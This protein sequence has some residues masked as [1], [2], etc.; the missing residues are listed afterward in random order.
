MGLPSNEPIAIVGMGCR[1]PGGASSPSK[2]WDLLREP[3]N[4]SKSIP[5]ERF[6]VERFYHPDGSHHGTC[7]VTESY[8]L[9]E[10]IRQFD[11]GFFGVPPGGNLPIFLAVI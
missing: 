11:A 10:D 2:L 9:D 1:F 6:N 5:T 3:R 7:N 4:T 8:L